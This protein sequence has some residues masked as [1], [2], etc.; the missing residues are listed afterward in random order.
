MAKTIPMIITNSNILVKDRETD[1]FKTFNMPGVNPVPNIPFYHKNGK[2]ASK[3]NGF[4]GLFHE[5]SQ[6]LLPI[7]ICI[8]Q[9]VSKHLTLLLH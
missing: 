7:L 2:K 5:C 9:I 4:I 8:F 3:I 1:E 6:N